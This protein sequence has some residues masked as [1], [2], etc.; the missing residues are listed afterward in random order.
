MAASEA[1]GASS[2]SLTTRA[3]AG[4]GT[5]GE[6]ALWLQAI[7][8][9]G[10]EEADWRKRGEEV[11]QLYRGGKPDAGRSSS[12]ARSRRFNIL[13]ANTETLAPATYNSLPIPDIRR[14][15]AEADPVSK[16]AA[17]I[18]ERNLSYSMERQDF[19]GVLQRAVK[20]ALLVGRAVSRVKYKPTFGGEP[21]GD[22][23]AGEAG[24]EAEP[25]GD[26]V[27]DEATCSETVSWA[28]FRRGPG[29]VW[30][31][32]PWVAF[33]HFLTR[34]ELNKLAPRVGIR[35]D[36]DA[37]VP[38][39]DDKADRDGQPPPDLFRR[40]TVWEVW[41]KEKR[42]VLFVAQAWPDAPLKV[43]DDP[44]G[45]GDFFPI[46]KPIYAIESPDDL[47]PVEPYRLYRDLAEELDIITRRI[48][49]LVSAM[50][51]RGAYIDP[52]IG[53][54]LSKFRDL[55]DGEITPLENPAQMLN[56]G[57][58]LDK[59]FWFMPIEQ[60]A[61]VIDRLY[62]ARE[63]VKQSIYEV[64]GIADIVRGAT[65]ATETAT[66]QQ[67]KSQWGNL[68]IQHLQAEVARFARDLLRIEAEIMAEKFA[69]ETLLAVAGMELPTEAEV[70][71]Q[72]TQQMAQMQP[73]Q[74]PGPA[75]QAKMAQTATMESVIRLLRDDAQRRFR[76]DIETDS[77]IRA[78]V[79]RQQENITGFV[80]GFGGF[81]QAIGPAVQ[82]QALPMKVAAEMIKSFSRAFKLGRSVEDALDEMP[83][84]QPPQADPAA[85]AAKAEEVKQQAETQRQQMKM[86][87]E[88]QAQAGEMQV[89]AAEA[90][91]T[92][93]SEA[94]KLQA[95]GYA[96]QMQA[97]VTLQ[98]KQMELEAQL[99]VEQ[100]RLTWERE[101]FE[102]EVALRQQEMA[103]QAD[104][105]RA[106]IAANAEAKRHATEAGYQA[107][108]EA[109]EAAA[110]RP[111]A[112]P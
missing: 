41:D 98:A 22:D 84:E 99:Q 75:E 26:S 32:V 45:L 3:D 31:D 49:A 54:F 110:K 65:K 38:G 48:T 87:A 86:Q 105:K 74:Q 61:A 43:M 82:S 2:A 20:D 102:A 16:A 77:T 80:Q 7:D 112:K 111:G 35:M 60:C 9:A 14:R 39:M 62:A 93:Q 21:S 108:S 15:F 33:R 107:K 4:E 25:A 109:T 11:V 5:A 70:M 83:T 55:K 90:Q 97:Q 72:V 96:A 50:K 66:A 89:R 42:R 52:N 51:W 63:Q 28:D 53:D 101:K 103:A 12:R 13:Y 95:E 85:A 18:L 58:G 34:D 36:M 92:Q 64:T 71:A 106:E 47:T 78:D 100:A 104:L 17:L 29:K 44:L 67:I 30:G 37:R 91:A 68:R 57:G 8:L 23:V 56:G 1:S 94:A 81:I 76:I 59:A 24:A 88:G 69:P 46:P 10:R 6:V 73:P 79:Q 40:A 27:L 19:D